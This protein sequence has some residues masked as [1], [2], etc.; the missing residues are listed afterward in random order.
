MSESCPTDPGVAQDTVVG[1]RS[2][3]DLAVTDERIP[4]GAIFRKS[5][6]CCRP[7]EGCAS[8]KARTDRLAKSGE[9]GNISVGQELQASLPDHLGELV[10]IERLVM[11]RKDQVVKLVVTHRT[12]RNLRFTQQRG[13]GPGSWSC[14]AAPSARIAR[15]SSTAYAG[16]LRSRRGSASD[17]VRRGTSA[18]RNH[19]TTRNRRP[20]GPDDGAGSPGF[21]A[22]HLERPRRRRR[23]TRCVEAAPPSST[24][25]RSACPGTRHRWGRTPR[26]YDAPTRARLDRDRHPM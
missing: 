12:E 8:R 5:T 21:S 14:T 24:S 15:A 3:L 1:G 9:P 19:R 25:H 10:K 11:L 6:Y 20:P 17:R 2:E 16:P 4:G 7:A 22:A 18:T 23:G 13:V 26:R